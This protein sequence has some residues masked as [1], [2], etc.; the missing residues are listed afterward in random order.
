M[1]QDNPS[2]I[3][4]LLYG[5]GINRPLLN[6]LRT[7]APEK[8]TKTDA[9]CYLLGKLGIDSATSGDSVHSRAMPSNTF[10]TSLSVLANKW[11]WTRQTVRRFVD[12]LVELELITMEPCYNGFVFSIPSPKSVILPYSSIEDLLEYGV[13]LF[14]QMP[15]MNVYTSDIA[16]LFT[17]YWTLRAQHTA[18][19]N[20]MV[21]RDDESSQ[22]ADLLSHKVLLIKQLVCVHTDADSTLFDDDPVLLSAVAATFNSNETD[23]SWT[24]NKWL[25]VLCV[26]LDAMRSDSKPMDILSRYNEDL[27]LAEADQKLAGQLYDYLIAHHIHVTEVATVSS[28][29]HPE[30][31][32]ASEGKFFKAHSD[33][34]VHAPSGSGTAD[35]AVVEAQHTVTIDTDMPDDDRTTTTA[36]NVVAD[37]HQQQSS[38]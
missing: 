36:Q 18:Q 10:S 27:C 2:L 21:L 3:S 13:H 5:P 38:L 26:I 22:S 17:L 12:S 20:G 19:G 34:S 24:W 33:A 11:H 31:A 6:L 30:R 4:Q 8:Y 29:F 32:D 9:Y 35:G 14:A 37:E 15:R 7:K 23:E 28:I 1:K 16:P 25:D